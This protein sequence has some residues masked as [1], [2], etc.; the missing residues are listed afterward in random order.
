MN[1]FQQIFHSSARGNIEKLAD[2]ID[3]VINFMDNAML[4]AIPFRE[5]IQ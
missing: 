1:F 3:P 4:C 5:E 2:L